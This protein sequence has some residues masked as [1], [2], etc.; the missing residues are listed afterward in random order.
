MKQTLFMK[1]LAE[2]FETFLPEIRHCSPNTISAYADSFVILFR[3]FD[4][5][6]SKTHYRIR[7]SDFTPKMFDEYILWMKNE[8]HYSPA[9]QKQRISAVTSF[10]KY[11]SRREVSALPALTAAASSRT[12]KVPEVLFPYFSAEEIK[13]LLHLPDGIGKYGLRDLALLCVLYDSAA[14]AQEMCDLRVEDFIPGSPARL[15][16]RG[17]GNKIREIPISKH[18]EQILKHYLSRQDPKFRETRETPLFFSQRNERM[19]TACIRNIVQKYVE[20]GRED[21][22]Q[23][24]AQEKYSPPSFR[25]S[26]A[27]HMLDAGVPLVYIRNFLGH[28]SVSTTERYA[29]VS[30]STMNRVLEKHSI[31]STITVK[32]R[33]EFNSSGPTKLPSFLTNKGR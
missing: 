12:P 19:T 17:K 20:R 23:L 2:Y 26:K 3:F 21:H 9:S 1:Q 22:P 5:Y 7:Y 28:E 32:D 33:G 27:I 11:A 6:M 8:L 24:F 31:A 10:L 16:L 14:R 4:E 18:T 30:Q 15:R 25:H 13:I 29:R